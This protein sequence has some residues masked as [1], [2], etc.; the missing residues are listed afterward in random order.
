[1]RHCQRVRIVHV[2]AG[3]RQGPDHDRDR[4]AIWRQAIF[5]PMRDVA[6]FAGD[7]AVAST[8]SCDIIPASY[9]GQGM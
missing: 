4:R 7:V 9:R 6:R 3:E 2:A 5:Y 8:L 1:L